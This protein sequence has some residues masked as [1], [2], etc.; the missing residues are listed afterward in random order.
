MQSKF[1][2]ANLR[3]RIKEKIRE[4]YSVGYAC[5]SSGLSQSNFNKYVLRSPEW[6]AIRELY[7]EMK[8]GS[9]W[10]SKLVRFNK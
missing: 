6:M 8:G 3:E 1:H 7:L 5:A 4:G 9:H 2:D 10:H